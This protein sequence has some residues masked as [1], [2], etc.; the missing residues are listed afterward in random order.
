[1]ADFGVCGWSWVYC[2]TLLGFGRVSSGFVVSCGRFFA[3]L[4]GGYGF[5]ADIFRKNG[6]FLTKL[7]ARFVT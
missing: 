1:V 7:C 2:P 3:V 6:P 5:V 4:P